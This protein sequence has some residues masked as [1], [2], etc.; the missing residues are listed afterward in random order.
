MKKIAV[1][2]SYKMLEERV[3]TE[4]LIYYLLSK[5]FFLKK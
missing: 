2:I 4:A 1:K 5:H 3:N